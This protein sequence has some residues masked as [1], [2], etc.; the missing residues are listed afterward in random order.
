MSDASAHDAIRLDLMHQVGQLP[1]LFRRDDARRIEPDQSD[2]S[3][4]G[5]QLSDLWFD[6]V[7]QVAREVFLTYVRPVPCVT[8]AIGLVPILRLRVVEA[9]LDAASLAGAG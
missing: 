7:L 1:A 2:R 8:V 5:E 3:V 4:I 6:F 9:Q